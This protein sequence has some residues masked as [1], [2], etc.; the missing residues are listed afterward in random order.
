MKIYNWISSQVYKLE[1]NTAAYIFNHKTNEFIELEGEAAVLWKYILNGYSYFEIKKFLERDNFSIEL[2]AFLTELH[3]ISLLSLDDK[4]TDEESMHFSDFSQH[5]NSINEFDF[6]RIRIFLYKN[7]FLGS[8]FI[9]TTYCCNLKCIH[10]L[11]DKSSS[12]Q[13]EFQDIKPIIDEAHKLG[14]F[15][16]TLSGGECTLNKDFIKIC[17]YIREKRM[18]LQFFTNGQSLYDNK[19]LF[20]KVISLYPYQIALSLYS[21]K[22]EIHDKITG[23]KGSHH[24]T[25][26]IIKKLKENNV[27]IRINCFLTK[28]NAYEYKDVEIFARNNDIGFMTDSGLFPNPSK[29]NYHCKITSKQLLDLYCNNTDFVNGLLKAP[30]LKSR[31]KEEICLAGRYGLTIKPDLNIYACFALKIPLG[32]CKNTSLEDIWKNKNSKLIEIRSLKGCDLKNCYKYDYCTYCSYCLGFAHSEGS[33]LQP[34]P[35]FCEDAK[36]K[37]KAVKLCG[38]CSDLH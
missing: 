20:N 22:P 38:V 29:S 15:L 14:V 28:Y 8:L 11:D 21:M 26:S 34:C 31:L 33:Y 2:D 1:D 7:G 25:L 27:N 16:V 9:V 19:D 35:R 4:D 36:I 5:C 18:A 32:N 24:K 13:I 37:M 6:A 23:V 12:K 10:C 30:K 3:S 17:E